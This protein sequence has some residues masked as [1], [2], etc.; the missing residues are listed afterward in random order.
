M[1]EKVEVPPNCL[2]KIPGVI[3]MPWTEVM[4]RIAKVWEPIM[5]RASVTVM[6]PR[7]RRVVSFSMWQGCELIVE[8]GIKIIKQKIVKLGINPEKMGWYCL[9]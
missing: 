4:P 7:C 1:I 5:N 2:R 3:S 8:S 9:K 6:S